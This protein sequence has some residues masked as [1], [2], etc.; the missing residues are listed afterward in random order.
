M[1]IIETS[2]FTRRVTELLSDEEYRKL[3]I[4]LVARPDAGAVIAGTGGL[5]KM[6]WG[7]EGRGKR[8]GVRIIYYRA[9]A[10]HQILMLLIYAKNQADD[11]TAQQKQ[12]LR[13]LVKEQF[14]ES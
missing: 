5:R 3:Q 12:V 2:V 11:L 14:D 1:V 9:V 7:V 6:R 13:A 8:G 10:R 4:E